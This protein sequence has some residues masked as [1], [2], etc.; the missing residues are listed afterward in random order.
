MRL[1]EAHS[2]SCLLAR[3][4]QPLALKVRGY[5]LSIPDERIYHGDGDMGREDDPHITIKY[6]IHTTDP[7]EVREKL[8]G[9]RSFRA[10]LGPVSIFNADGYSVLKINV[11]G[12]S[13]RKLNRFVSSS[14]KCTDTFPE[15]NPHCTIAYVNKDEADPYWFKSYWTDE[16][17]GIPVEFNS[18]VFSVPS[19]EKYNIPLKGVAPLEEVEMNKAAAELLR[20]AKRVLGG[21]QYDTLN[22]AALVTGNDKYLSGST[23][24]WY[25][26]RSFFRDGIMGVDWLIEHDMVPNMR[27]IDDTHEH[28]GDIRERGFEKVWR[29]MQ[30]E[31]WSPRG[32]ARKLIMKK[33]LGHTSMSVGDVIQQGSQLFMVD[34][35]GFRRID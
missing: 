31:E 24:I 28:L 5:G 9:Q 6:G 12:L 22:D 25:M 19:G 23:G 8:A 34:R 32:E 33:G 7:D 14:F 26:K 13:I 29:M 2:Y 18:L 1:L 17:E 4:P 21:E 20:V 16:F 27:T 10:I 15:Y 35:A 30:G 3:L 11:E